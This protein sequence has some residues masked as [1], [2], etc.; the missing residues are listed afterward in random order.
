MQLEFSLAQPSWY[1]SHY[2]MPYK[3]V[4]KHVIFGAFLFLVQSIF[5]YFWGIFDKQLFHSHLLDMRLVIAIRS[6]G[7][8]WLFTISHPTR[9]YG[10]IVN[11]TM[12][13]KIHPVRIQV[14]RCIFD[15]V[16]TKLP[17]VCTGYVSLMVVATVF[18]LHGIKQL[19]NAL[20]W[21]VV[22]HGISPCHLYFLACTRALRIFH[23]IIHQIYHFR[24]IGLD[25]SCDQLKLKKF[26]NFPQ[27]SKLHI[28]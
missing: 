21:F 15:S 24:A 17:I 26:P 13:E 22:Y 2:T 18:S 5:L 8:R 12:P 23:V 19:C 11:Y 10:I 14:S 9:A 28:F 4:K 20:S 3:Y 27:F 16:T 1:M 7:L 6:Y 25:A